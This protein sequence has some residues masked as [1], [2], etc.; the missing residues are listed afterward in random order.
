M[1]FKVEWEGQKYVLSESGFY[2][3]RTF[4]RPPEAVQQHLKSA[5]AQQL[6]QASENERNLTSLL[7]YSGIAKKLGYLNLALKFVERVLVSEPRN[8]FAVARASSILRA[9]G[10]PQKALAV[11]NRIPENQQGHVL[12]TTR[13]AA[14]CDLGHYHEAMTVIRRALALLRG[15]PKIEATEALSVYGRIR[16]ALDGAIE[17]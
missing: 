11:T 7:N 12:L 5:Y 6:K 2:N 15:R 16:S 9:K 1:S 10:Q 4:L 17:R 14:L 3:A 8:G 13:A